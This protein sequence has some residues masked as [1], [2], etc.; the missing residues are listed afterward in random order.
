MLNTPLVYGLSAFFRT[1]LFGYVTWITRTNTPG[2]EK[3][4]YSTWVSV[5]KFLRTKQW[6]RYTLT[7]WHSI[8][9]TSTGT[10]RRI[11]LQPKG[12]LSW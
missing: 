1:P 9:D 12:W 2:I 6:F 10:F 11:A 7:K 4:A 3:S 5:Y 8:H